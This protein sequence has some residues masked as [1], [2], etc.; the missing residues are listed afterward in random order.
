M[1]LVW[2]LLKQHI[3][4]A[5]MA[6]F[7]F[8]NLFGMF[9]VLLA[10]Q[11]YRDVLPLFT[12]KDS[13]MKSEYLV[14]SKGDGN[15]FSAEEVNNLKTQPFVEAVGAFTSAA[16]PLEARLTMEGTETLHSELSVES[17][18]DDFVEIPVAE[19]H[20]DEQKKE[21]PMLLP[22]SYMAMYNVGLARNKKLPKINEGVLGMVKIDLYAHGNGVERHFNG[23]IVGFSNRIDCV[24]VPQEFIRW[25]NKKF[26][27]QEDNSPTRLMVSV[28]NP[29]DERL[30][31]Y[32]EE[33]G[34]IVQKDNEQTSKM[35]YFLRTIVAMLLLV[36]LLISMLSFYILLLSIWLLVQKNETKIANLRLIG[37]SPAEVARPYQRLSM[38]LNALVLVLALVLVGIVRHFYIG[39]FETLLP[40]SD[41]R[42]ILPAV[43]LG[44]MLFC[45]ITILDLVAIRKKINHIEK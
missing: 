19:W 44:F 20:F 37:Y 40:S 36:G 25:S 9:V 11:F 27:P 23:R 15:K 5:Q 34:Y 29:T 22:R 10:Y 42:S 12:A 32:A 21:V 14:V 2:K 39:I 30:T 31:E 45:F 3:S 18:P 38:I 1:N 24:L 33:K 41:T 17:V 28:E 16:F 13:F 4:G 6:G 43:G 26:A 7:F 35:V 8:A